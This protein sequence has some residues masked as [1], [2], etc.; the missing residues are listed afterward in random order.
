MVPAQA[1]PSKEDLMSSLHLTDTQLVL[2]SAASQ[3]D[4]GLIVRP[5]RLKGGA[6]RIVADKLVTAGLAEETSVAAGALHWRNDQS[7]RR[8]GLKITAAGLQAIGVGD[9]RIGSAPSAGEGGPTVAK[10]ASPAPRLHR[11]G[12]KQALVLS[13][14]QREQGATLDELVAVTHWLPHTTRAALTRLRRDHTITRTRE[15]SRASVY[16]LACREGDVTAHGLGK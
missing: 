2:L 3:R 16:R 11:A 15:A 9:Q 14:L 12:P 4:D 10:P 1:E 8:I 5:D 6:A 13:L 7:G